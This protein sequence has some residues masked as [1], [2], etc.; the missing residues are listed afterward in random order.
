MEGDRLSSIKTALLSFVPNVCEFA[1]VMIKLVLFNHETLI[2]DVPQDP[3]DAK[4]LIE[5]HVVVRGGTDFYLA[6][7]A[8]VKCADG[9]LTNHPTYQVLFVWV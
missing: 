4:K 9:V 6:S 5:K 1:N 8:L 2:L 7:Q 3:D